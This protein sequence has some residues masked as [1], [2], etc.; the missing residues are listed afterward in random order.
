MKMKVS[1]ILP[2]VFLIYFCCGTVFS[3]PPIHTAEESSSF[4]ED[5]TDQNDIKTKSTTPSTTTTTT[6]ASSSSGS[7][8]LEIWTT[9]TE[10]PTE[11]TTSEVIDR[12]DD[13]DHSQT[14]GN[15]NIIRDSANYDEIPPNRAH[16]LDSLAYCKILFV[17]QS[18]PNISNHLNM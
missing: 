10:I 4:T 7:P 2:V 15:V 11:E 13:L 8:S 16:P 12:M 14:L 3:A 9:S 5:S 6:G 17:L 18:N 1:Q